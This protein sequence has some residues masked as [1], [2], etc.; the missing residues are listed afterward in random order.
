M[1]QEKVKNLGVAAKK[2]GERLAGMEKLPY[3][4]TRKRE[5]GSL[6]LSG[7][8]LTLAPLAG[9]GGSRKRCS[10]RGGGPPRADSHG[11]TPERW[12]PRDEGLHGLKPE[13]R[14]PRDGTEEVT[15]AG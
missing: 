7:L 14:S 4:C 1:S 15:S 8:F 11:Q 12:I 13:R 10:P 9:Q 2:V 5:T 3:L 6:N